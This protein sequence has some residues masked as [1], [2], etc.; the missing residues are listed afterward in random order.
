MAI[1]RGN[2]NKQ[3]K[4]GDKMYD[5]SDYDVKDLFKIKDA[6]VILLAYSLENDDMLQAVKE[7]L[8]KRIEA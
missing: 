2:K 4:G 5:F 3:T 6:L 7:E 8:N 1:L